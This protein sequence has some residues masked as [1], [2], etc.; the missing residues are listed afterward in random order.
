MAAAKGRIPMT[1]SSDTIPCPPPSTPSLALAEAIEF[2]ARVTVRE[3]E[4]RMK[5]AKKGAGR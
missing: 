5:A 4:R 3:S 1:K 2:C